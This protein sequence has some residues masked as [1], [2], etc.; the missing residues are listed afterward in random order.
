[1]FGWG[2]KKT[3]AASVGM[4][5]KPVHLVSGGNRG[6]RTNERRARRNAKRIE[7]LK[8]MLAAGRGDKSSIMAEIQRR[9]G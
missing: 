2:K 6:Q 9:G 4:E 5:G 7:R 8:A 1:M 3:G